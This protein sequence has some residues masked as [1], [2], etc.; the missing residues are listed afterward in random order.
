MKKRKFTPTEWV[1]I[2]LL[3]FMT[4]LTTLNVFSRYALHMSISLTEEITS[5][6]FGFLS[7][8]GAAIAAE[9]GAHLGLTAIT[10]LLSPKLNH[11]IQILGC[12]ISSLLLFL[13]LILGGD[14]VMHQ[15]EIGNVSPGLQWPEWIF[16][17]MV[18]LGCALVA[19]SFLRKGI[20]LLREGGDAK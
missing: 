4:A 13:I 18:P 12:F 1:A 15:L 5:N 6:M 19:G 8:I 7:F 3:L 17:S 9:R 14:M 10:D 16:G 2:S 20:R 11:K